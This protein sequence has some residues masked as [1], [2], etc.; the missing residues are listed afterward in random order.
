KLYE[1]GLAL[2]DRDSQDRIKR[3]Y[4]RADSYRC[5]LGRLLPRLVLLQLGFRTDEIIFSRTTSGKP[6]LV[7]SR[8]DHTI[9]FNIS[10]DQ[11]IV[12]MAFQTLEYDPS[13]TAF[14]APQPDDRQPITLIGVDVMRIAL[15]QFAKSLRAFVSTIEDTVRSSDSDAPEQLQEQN[16]GLRYLFIIWTL[17]EAYTKALGLGMGF[18]FRRIE[19]R[20]RPQYEGEKKTGYSG[21]D[22]RL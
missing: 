21:T 22:I 15:P 13:R 11:A 16:D 5:L 8:L 2:V 6:F 14:A 17:K 10:H 7:T 9:G 3:F 4:H 12:V 20:I 18:D 1:T 19:C